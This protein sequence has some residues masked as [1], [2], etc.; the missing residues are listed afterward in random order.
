ML[1]FIYLTGTITHEV[2]RRSV[3]FCVVY[4]YGMYAIPHTLSYV[5]VVVLRCHDRLVRAIWL[6]IYLSTHQYTLY[7]C[8]TGDRLTVI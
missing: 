7:L 3:Q 8:V 2:G 6:G 4:T 5:D 1:R